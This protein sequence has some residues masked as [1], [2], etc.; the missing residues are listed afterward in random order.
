MKELEEQYET[1]RKQREATDKELE[2]L[3]EYVCRLEEAIEGV[4]TLIRQKH[5]MIEGLYSDNVKPV[6]P[7]PGKPISEIMNDE[8]R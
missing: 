6:K 5:S 2:D 7:T 8:R 3:K 1:L 4:C